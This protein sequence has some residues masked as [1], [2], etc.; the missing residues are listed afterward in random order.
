MKKIIKDMISE[1]DKTM[2]ILSFPSTS[3]TLSSVLELVTNSKKQ[4]EGMSAILNRCKV[5][6]ALNMMDLSVEAE[7]FGAEIKYSAQE[8]PTV[9]KGIISDISE[10]NEVLIPPVGK[11]RT[12][13]YIEGVRLAKQQISEV[14]VFCGVIG[15]YSLSGRLYDMT[16]LMMACYD[17][18][19]SV[20]KLLEKCTTFIINYINAFKKVGADGV[21]MAE[22][23]AG[24]LSPT[25]CEEFSN[26]YVKRIFEE[27]NDEDFVLVYHNCGNTI[28]LIPSIK[29]LGADIYHFGNAVDM[30]EVLKRMP[31]DVI[32]MGNI[33]PVDFRN[34]TK[35]KIYSSSIDL[36]TRCSVYPN[37]IISS[38]CD[39][40]F[41][42]DWDNI[43]AYF[44]AVKDYYCENIS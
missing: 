17:D 37:F 3:L 27:V 33:N 41:D 18:E 30:E 28:P 36:L 34:S 9:T 14:P 31:S 22:P 15:P 43:D 44:E 8:I 35:D 11:G 39:I 19:E 6:A 24:L 5:S 25:L 10:V 42:S 16:E 38:G 21:I 23:A 2:P 32:V 13:I 26:R 12:G 29:E 40:P 4:V 20:H 1:K 7:A